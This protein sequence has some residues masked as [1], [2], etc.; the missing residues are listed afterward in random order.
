MIEKQQ[1][2]D[3]QKTDDKAILGKGLCLPGSSALASGGQDFR[4]S[5]LWYS[6]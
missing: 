2:F 4:G 6:N 5:T 1:G 3:H